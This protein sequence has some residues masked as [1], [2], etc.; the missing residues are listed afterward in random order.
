MMLPWCSKTISVFN[1]ASKQQQVLLCA[2]TL[3][4]L[5]NLEGWREEEELGPQE[6]CSEITPTSR[7]RTGAQR[8]WVVTPMDCP[9]VTM[10]IGTQQVSIDSPVLILL[11]WVRHIQV[12]SSV[13]KNKVFCGCYCCFPQD[14]IFVI[15]LKKTILHHGYLRTCIS[16]SKIF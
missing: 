16:L 4:S 6:A 2:L 14:H 10:V 11:S 1:P 8:R 7:S 13:R 9:T 5:E 15:I 12:F 3:V